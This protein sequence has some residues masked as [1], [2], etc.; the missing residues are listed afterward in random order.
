MFL[1]TIYKS[2]TYI[3]I[4][5]TLQFK[6][7]ILKTHSVCRLVCAYEND[8]WRLYKVLMGNICVIQWVIWFGL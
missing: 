3:K 5:N 4:K 8:G 7:A 1:A 6:T 2:N